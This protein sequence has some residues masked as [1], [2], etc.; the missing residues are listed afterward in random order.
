MI[1]QGFTFAVAPMMDWTDR[2]CRVFH[3]MLSARALL[4]TEMV[5]AD[6]V[7]HGDRD[8]LIGY[9]AVEHKVALQLGGS[10]PAKLA[11]AT[12][13]AQDFGY[14]EVNLNV[15]CPSDRVRSGQ[16]G[17]SLMAKPELVADCFDAMQAVVDIPV[18]I[19][20][21]IGIDDQEPHETLPHFIE[22]V[23]GAGCRHFIIHARKAWLEGLS[24]KDNR[25]IPPLDYELVHAMKAQF[26][27]AE[28][29]LNGGLKTLE[30][31]QADFVSADGL[32]LDGVMFGRAAYDQ[33]WLL[34]GVDEMFFGGEAFVKPRSEI[35]DGLIA[36]CEHKEKTDPSTKAIIRHIM[37][38]YH[39]QMGGRI[40]RRALSEA[41]AHLTPSEKIR[42]A[43]TVLNHFQKQAS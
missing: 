3:R 18:T 26:S 22:T 36:Y 1:N 17:A 20:C 35:V 43:H 8:H 13:I 42:Q 5:V 9:N 21:R 14:D 30:Q 23:K 7:I 38:L 4:Y 32:A 33:P 24:P 31:A 15:G 12:R 10:D 40:W 28:I 34:T 2:H 41:D 19:K 27:D 16:F 37:G 11:Q 6:A 25:R 39:G 29:V